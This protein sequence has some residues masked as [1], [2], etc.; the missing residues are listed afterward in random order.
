MASMAAADPTS[1]M[2]TYSKVISSQYAPVIG[3]E[4]AIR[5]ATSFLIN[6]K[7]FKLFY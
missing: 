7:V 2:S 6:P 5:T 4:E 3:Q 1:I